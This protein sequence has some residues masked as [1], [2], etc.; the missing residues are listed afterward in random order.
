MG[1]WAY[2]A[3]RIRT[4]LRADGREAVRALLLAAAVA[5]LARGLLILPLRAR[6]PGVRRA[7]R[8][9]GA[10]DGVP[11]P[12]RAGAGSAARGRDGLSGGGAWC[13]VM[14]GV[15]LFH[16]NMYMH[17]SDDYGPSFSLAPRDDGARTFDAEC[18]AR[19]KSTMM[20]SSSVPGAFLAISSTLS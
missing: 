5:L 6:M 18:T 12:A 8:L 16:D 9:G 1:A 2:V 11:A 3:P 15:L 7:H 14:L 20:T 17:T 19:H 4:A 13:R 10:R